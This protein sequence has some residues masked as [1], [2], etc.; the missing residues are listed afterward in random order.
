MTLLV[1]ART[2]PAVIASPQGEAIPL[3]SH[4]IAAG[5]ARSR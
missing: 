5:C 4:E 1:I 3:L 2:D